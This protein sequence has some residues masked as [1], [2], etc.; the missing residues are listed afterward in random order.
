LPIGIAGNEENPEIVDYNN[1][2]Q[3]FIDIRSAWFHENPDE[4]DFLFVSMKITN[5]YK[6]IF[7]GEYGLFWIFNGIKYGVYGGLDHILFENLGWKC[8][9][10]TGV[11]QVIFKIW[12]IVRHKLIEKLAL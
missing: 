6:S 10:I 12:L 4:P 1:D 2:A 11:L 7:G 9:G 5:L 8:G 3:Q